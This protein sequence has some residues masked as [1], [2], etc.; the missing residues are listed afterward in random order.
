MSGHTRGPWE[1]ERD[2]EDIITVSDAEG[3][4]VAELNYMAVNRRWQDENPDTHWASGGDAACRTVDTE[5]LHANALLIAAAPDLL[6][7]VQRFLHVVEGH[8]WEGSISGEGQ[9]VE[10]AREAIAKAEGRAT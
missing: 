3:F 2:V 10:E 8:G 6:A 1:A 4:E 7:V 5:E 9:V